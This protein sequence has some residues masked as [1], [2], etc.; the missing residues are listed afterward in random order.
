[1]VAARGNFQIGIAPFRHHRQ[2]YFHTGLTREL[3]SGLE[4]LLH[5]AGASVH[6]FAGAFRELLGESES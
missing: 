5:A 1:M 6:E 2:D 4:Q 3:R